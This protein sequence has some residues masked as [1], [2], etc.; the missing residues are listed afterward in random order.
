MANEELYSIT[1]IE[2]VKRHR[3]SGAKE[4]RV[5]IESSSHGV[6][7]ERLAKPPGFTHHPRAAQ[8]TGRETE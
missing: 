1:R 2:H 7:V 4:F 8:A 6:P 3:D 5:G